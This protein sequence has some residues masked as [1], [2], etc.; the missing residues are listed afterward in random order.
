MSKLGHLF[1]YLGIRQS[2]NV[3]LDL[4]KG[5]LIDSDWFLFIFSVF[6]CN[7]LQFYFSVITPFTSRNCVC[8]I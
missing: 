5:T 3:E 2:A 4:G 6:I 8:V 7:G 1:I